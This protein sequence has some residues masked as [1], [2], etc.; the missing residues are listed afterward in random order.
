VKTIPWLKKIVRGKSEL[1][2]CLTAILKKNRS[3]ER[4]DHGKFIQAVGWEEPRENLKGRMHRE[5][6]KV[7]TRGMGENIRRVR[8]GTISA[9]SK[10][11]E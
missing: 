10:S 4:R 8:G 11:W 3:A 9:R 6:R 1:R 7:S 2:N 5:E